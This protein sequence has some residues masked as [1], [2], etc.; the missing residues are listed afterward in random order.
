[1][2]TLV[3]FRFTLELKGGGLSGNE[4]QGLR[5]NSNSEGAE[6]ASDKVGS[7]GSEAAEMAQE[8]C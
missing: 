3:S 6:T 7:P 5:I 4:M 1:M 8:R 2:Y